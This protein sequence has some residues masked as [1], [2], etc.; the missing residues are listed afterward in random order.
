MVFTI[1]TIVFVPM[2]F[3]A[4]FFAINIAEF[5][6]GRNDSPSLPLRYVSKYLFGIGL[7]I[8][9]PFIFLA[10][11]VDDV[12][13]LFRRLT[14]PLTKRLSR[15]LS[16]KQQQQQRRPR[17][18]HDADGTAG[19][20]MLAWARR[21]SVS[22]YSATEKARETFEDDDD[23]DGGGGGG[24]GGGG[25]MIGDGRISLGLDRDLSPMSNRTRLSSGAAN[26]VAWAR[27]DYDRSR[28][29]YSADLERG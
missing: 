15:L 13:G 4:S 3:I 29:R 8:S 19:D 16:G 20:R 18:P 28:G 26:H 6:Q 12:V 1:V 11:A 23:N 7:G 22:G 5:P 14:S 2:S 27:G 17:T 9:I 10:F 21:H 24:G 25:A